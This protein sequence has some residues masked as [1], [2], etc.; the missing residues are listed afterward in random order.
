MHIGTYT[1]D[2]SGVLSPKEFEDLVPKAKR[3]ATNQGG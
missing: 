3:Q 1:P 2:V